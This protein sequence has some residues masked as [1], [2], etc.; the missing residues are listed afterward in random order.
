MS[1]SVTIGVV[2]VIVLAGGYLLFN[3]TSLYKSSSTSTPKT[4]VINTAADV[5]VAANI[6]YANNGFSPSLTTVKSGDVVAITNSSPNDLQM[7]SDP[8]PAHTDDTDLN[9]GVVKASSTKNFTV[10]KTGKFGFHNHLNPS[11]TAEITIQ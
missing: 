4:A 1:K 11:H 9:V 5:K 3:K 10:T 6:T 7:Q 2:I 8:H